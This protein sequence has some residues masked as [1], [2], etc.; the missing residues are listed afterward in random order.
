[1]NA[2]SMDLILS[3]SFKVDTYLSPKGALTFKVTENIKYASP[4]FTV[5]VV[6]VMDIENKP[7]IKEF[8]DIE[9]VREF[10]GSVVEAADEFL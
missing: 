10:I 1:M 2:L 6:G 5:E 4:H 3:S 7:I 9:A 8:F